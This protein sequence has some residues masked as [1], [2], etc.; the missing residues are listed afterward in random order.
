[1]SVAE[2]PMTV[3]EPLPSELDD[4]SRRLVGARRNAAALARFPGV[5]PATLAE[6]YA[7]QTASIARWPD[8]VAGWKVGGIQPEY[9]EALAAERLSGPIFRQS[10]VDVVPGSTLT[11]PIY[12]GGFAAI[13]AEFVFRLGTTVAPREARYTDADLIE[14]VAALHVGAEIAS[15]P[16]AAVNRLGP[17]CV[18]CDFGNNAGLLVGPEI[19]HWTDIDARA[20]TAAVSVDG[21]VV[22]TASAAAVEGGLLQALRFLLSLS[23]ARGLTLPAGTLVSCGAVTGI[24]DVTTA[25]SAT[26]DFGPTGSFDVTFAAM[27][28]LPDRAAT[29]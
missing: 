24:H 29:V 1:M 21:S 27:K 5:V 2:Q 3:I 23:A 16:M 13:E 6:A 9:R 10:V 15:S 25:S 20:M 26:V 4:I 14:R 28:P 11:A 18:V 22:G 8:S 19:P 17:C 7:V 12:H